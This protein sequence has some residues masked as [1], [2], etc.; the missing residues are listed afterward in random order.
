MRFRHGVFD[1]ASV[2]VISLATISGIGREAGVN[3]DRRRFR[4]NIVLETSAG[5]PFAEAEWVGGRLGF[6]GNGSG[7]VV[8]VTARDVRCV[9]VN[10][11]PDTAAQD[12][13]V[14]KAVVGLNG[15]T[16][17][18]Y[19]TVVRTGSIRVGDPVRLAAESRR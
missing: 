18:V 7:P 2:S 17:G 12:P 3:L 13:R 6:G 16:A 10:L 8:N 9:M 19:A 15:N 14:L 11:D 4:A 5:V 1:D